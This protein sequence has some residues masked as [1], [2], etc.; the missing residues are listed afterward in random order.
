M[1]DQ[2]LLLERTADSAVPRT[3]RDRQRTFDTAVGSEHGSEVPRATDECRGRFPVCRSS[4]SKQSNYQSR[5]ETLQ[6][7]S[8]TTQIR[9]RTL[10]RV[11]TSEFPVAK[12][13]VYIGRCGSG[14]H[15]TTE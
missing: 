7:P 15:G 9:W 11:P 10:Y 2:D 13:A 1:A 4:L 6:R 3:S 14:R 8:T 5:S 12:S